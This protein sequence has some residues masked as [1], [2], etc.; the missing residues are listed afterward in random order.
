M[1][2]NL[3][4]VESPTK[5]KM[6]QKF[7]GKDFV[8]ESSFGHIRDL[9]NKKSELPPSQQKLPYATLAIDVDNDFSPLYIIPPKSK[10]HAAKLK[11]LLG[12][13]TTIWLASDEDREGEAISWHL[14]EVLKPKKT[15]AIHRIVFHE[16]TKNAILD[17]VKHPRTVDQNLVDAQQARRILDRLVGYKV[18]PI[19]WKKIRF[20]LSAG[21]VQSVAVKILV[22]REREIRAFV[23]E[24]FWSITA[25]LKKDGKTFPAQ[26]QRLDGTKFVPKNAVEAEAIFSAISG[27]DFTV[28]NIDEKEVSRKPAPPFT[29]STLQQE[30]ARKLGFSVKKTMMLAQKLYEGI[31]AGGE[32]GGL[33]TYM[34]TDS[35]NLSEK[36]LTDAEKVISKK[37]GKNFHEKRVF[38]KKQKGAQEAHEAIRPTEVSRT[39]DEIYALPKT[40]L[41]A[42]ARSLYEL[43]WQRTLASQMADARLMQS[44]IDFEVLGK[45]GSKKSHLF[46]ATGQRVVFS[47]FRKVYQED[48]DDEV[49]ENEENILPEFTIGEK[50][51]PEKIEKKQHFTKPP[52]RYTE[53]SLVKKMESEGIGRPST[54]A[55]TISTIQGR[56]YVVREGRQLV[57]T[58]TA[59]VVTD[60]LAAHFADTVD[61]AFTAKMENSLDEIAENKMDRVK[62]L[63]KFWTDF[64]ATLEKGEEV[65]RSAAKKERELGKCPNTGKPIFAKYGRF[66][67][68]LQR[69]ETE[70]EEK[71]DFAP[72]LS[73]QDLETITLED[74][75]QNFQLPRIL[76]R[77]G[78]IEIRVSVGKFGPYIQKDK[79]FASLPENEIFTIDL[80]TAIEKLH[81]KEVAAKNRII[82]DYGEVQ[83]LNGKFGPYITN[84]KKNAKIPAD[85]DPAKISEKKARELLEKA[86]EKKGRWGGRKKS[87]E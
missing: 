36:A 45:A 27:Q 41:D 76:G 25:S 50:T 30:A 15:N 69:G 57:P 61:L 73:T 23:A 3:V 22:D 33:I 67:A 70:S 62:F 44:G 34:R 35:V 43:I 48:R 28:K 72:I 16:I 46:R 37:Y 19:L 81:E 49:D 79:I 66:G 83:I 54:Y 77:E 10:P 55:P 78:E 1:T 60:F 8:V 38:S 21:R 31:D 84:G 74:A 7:L 26:F 2:K 47:G 18:S 32:A 58:D 42:D 40:K 52:A 87:Q 17:A 39:P 20:G 12:A 86:P 56:G 51:R 14:L 71:P 82:A 64:S 80:P 24:E 53:A 6:L 75:I 11:K 68:M 9:P 63:K 65:S 13:D 5:A 4:I 59:F 85:T 29:T